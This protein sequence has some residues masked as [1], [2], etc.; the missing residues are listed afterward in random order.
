MYSLSNQR[1]NT[2]TY[3]VIS[4]KNPI[5][6][7]P[8][9]HTGHDAQHLGLDNNKREHSARSI[10]T[11]KTSQLQNCASGPYRPA[12]GPADN[13]REHKAS[14][15]TRKTSLA[16]A[17]A[18]IDDER[19]IVLLVHTG[20]DARHLRQADRRR[21]HSAWRNIT[22]KTSIASMPLPLSTTSAAMKRG[23]TR[24]PPLP[25]L[26][27]P[28]GTGGRLGGIV[29]VQGNREFLHP[30]FLKRRARLQVQERQELTLQH[31]APCTPLLLHRLNLLHL[32][33]PRLL[34]LI[35]L[36]LECDLEEK[37]Q[38]RVVNCVGR[39]IGQRRRQ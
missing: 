34:L 15:E 3:D 23:G 37:G 19:A 11:S 35:L 2:E 9:R 28:R 18:R 10:V 26:L 4:Q 33:F 5:F 29:G 24:S 8:S 27:P 38:R 14:R 32:H 13:Q 6:L 21:E 12:R 20:Q 22:R 7:Y 30:A 39:R 31:L 1:P 17:T 25:L 16:H 36:Q